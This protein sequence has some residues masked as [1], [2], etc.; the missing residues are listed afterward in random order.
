[1]EALL[2]Q[3]TSQ[4]PYIHFNNADGF[5]EIKGRSIP[6]NSDAFWLP[7]LNWFESYLTNPFKST[8]F[9]IELD[10]LNIQS[11]KRI[12][13]LLY[14]LNELIETGQEVH[15]EWIYR[16]NDDEM[17]EVGQDYAYMVKVPFIFKE[18]TEV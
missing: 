10:Y 18:F 5:M 4:T 13:F 16:K 3:S 17:Y 14:T 7:V 8:I 1:M 9:R 15:V 2:I 12:L 6:D 11:S